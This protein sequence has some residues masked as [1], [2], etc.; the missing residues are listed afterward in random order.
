[1]A[2]E[3]QE[4]V[5]R[6]DFMLWVGWG[7]LF[8]VFGGMM[9][10]TIK[11]VFPNVLYEP[12]TTFKA[13]KPGDFA[14]DSITFL[15]EKKVFLFRDKDGSFHAISAVCTHLGC[16]VRQ[17]AGGFFCPCHGSV[18]D[19]NGLVISGPAP[20]P[21]P[22][23]SVVLTRRGELEIDVGKPVQAGYKLKV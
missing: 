23:L 21:L 15:P 16:T 3:R 9:E 18:F 20:K 8:I 7:S 6:R 22:W 13:G 14:L 11:F 10:E 5:G 2:E 1:M 12:A 17:E 19:G 4:I